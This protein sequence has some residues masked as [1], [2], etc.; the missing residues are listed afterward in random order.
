MKNNTYQ[1]TSVARSHIYRGQNESA[2]HNASER[3]NSYDHIEI[4]KHINAIYNDIFTKARSLS[5]QG[6]AN[7]ESLLS[8]EENNDINKRMNAIEGSDE[9]YH[10]TFRSFKDNVFTTGSQTI[11]EARRLR[12]DSVYGQVTLP[13][14]GSASL[15]FSR[16]VIEDTVFVS[17]S[18]SY[19]V[20]SIDEG[21]GTV[22]EGQVENA[23]NGTNEDF[24]L[25]EVSFPLDSDKESVTVRL[26]VNLPTSFQKNANMIQV[27]P[28]V[29][30]WVD[31][32]DI[33]YSITGADPSITLP[34][35]SPVYN[36]S[37]TRHIFAPL[38]ITKL[39][40]TLRTRNFIQN[41][42]RKVFLNGLEELSLELV[43]FDQTFDS[44][45]LLDNNAI[46]T[47]IEAADGYKFSKIKNFFS[48]PDY[49]LAARDTGI[50]HKIFTDSTLSDLVWYSY[51]DPNPFDANIDVAAKN[52]STLYVVTMLEY[53]TALGTPPV[54][55]HFALK[56]DTEAL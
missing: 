36:A 55:D 51:S 18:L 40:V 37:E 21:S 8:L 28:S 45:K 23:F 1:P 14:N 48:N 35:F 7:R 3:E 56:Y 22:T 44:G 34:G 49:E 19:S 17:P 33:Q 20:D 24:W 43:E 25:R 15:F 2:K 38:G 4:A 16:N 47:K 50:Y 46:I 54:L 31:I 53:T 30:G 26:N 10:Q 32:L 11:E 42:G 9:T 13:Y 41:N 29:P 39:S 52:T 6:K 5:S 27:R 12:M